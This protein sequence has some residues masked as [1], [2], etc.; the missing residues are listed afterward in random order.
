VWLCPLVFAC[1][2]AVAFISPPKNGGDRISLD[3]LLLGFAAA[4]VFA[5]W[6]RSAFHSSI[7]VAED[8]ITYLRGK[9]AVTVRW[10][11]IQRVEYRRFAQRLKVFATTGVVINIEK[12]LVGFSEIAETVFRRT[13][14]P[15]SGIA[16]VRPTPITE[17]AISIAASNWTKLLMLLLIG[18]A[19]YWFSIRFLILAWRDRRMILLAV[20]L[21][22]AWFVWRAA[23]NW[24]YQLALRLDMNAAGIRFCQRDVEISAS[25]SDIS[26][27]RLEHDDGMSWF[28]VRNRQ[29]EPI[30]TL[31]REMFNWSGV[32]MKRFDKLVQAASQRSGG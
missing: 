6:A 26:T 3:A 10:H 19:A 29:R 13:G 25:W 16:R 22:G 5:V 30:L 14:Q 7:E 8:G 23:R 12:Q 27:A 1:L 20:A 24:W 31:R 4:I 11:E 32:A 17:P 18:V 15:S 9:R 21:L 2:L 28:V